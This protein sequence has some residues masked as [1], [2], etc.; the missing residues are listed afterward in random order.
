M[1]EGGDIWMFITLAPNV[2]PFVSLKSSGTLIEF[3]LVG[4]LSCDFKCFNH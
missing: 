2:L 1:Q 4:V 3:W